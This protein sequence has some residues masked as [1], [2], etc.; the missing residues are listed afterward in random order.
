MHS[1][2]VWLCSTLLLIN[3]FAQANPIKP[4]KKHSAFDIDPKLKTV[5]IA[6][7]A[8]PIQQ[9]PEAILLSKSK[10]VKEFDDNLKQT[11]FDMLQAMY[12]A[13]G[14]GLAA[15]QLNL[16]L[17]IFVM[18][19]GLVTPSPKVFINPIIL[20]ASEEKFSFPEGCLSV[21][22][23][24]ES[25]KRSKTVTISAQTLTGK[26]VTEQFSGLAAICI[27]HEIDHLNGILFI[28]RLSQE[29]RAKYHLDKKETSKS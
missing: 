13:N 16:S 1:F 23:I 26:K 14:V 10:P 27:Q 4:N 28:D 6:K 21:A 20:S 17:Q 12:K 8:L 24:M 7:P 15:P 9:Y 5:L 3:G 2:F 18:D 19:V 29:K 22:H 11:A 25:I